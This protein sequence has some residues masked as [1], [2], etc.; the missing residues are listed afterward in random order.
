MYSL[1][2]LL[3]NLL[4]AESG[5]SVYS[6]NPSKAAAPFVIKDIGSAKYVVQA[7]EPSVGTG[8]DDNGQ[9]WYFE[10]TPTMEV[11]VMGGGQVELLSL[12]IVE[13]TNIFSEDKMEHVESPAS[14][15]SPWVLEIY[16]KDESRPMDFTFQGTVREGTK[17]K[18]FAESVTI[19][20]VYP[21]GVQQTSK[22]ISPDD[23]VKLAKQG[24]TFE[25]RDTS[26][27]IRQQEAYADQD[28]YE[29]RQSNAQKKA[30]HRQE[31]ARQFAD[32]E[33]S[34]RF[35]EQM[36]QESIERKQKEEEYWETLNTHMRDIQEAHEA[37]QKSAKQQTT[38]YYSP[39]NVA[40]SSSTSQSSSYSSGSGGSSSSTASETTSKYETAVDCRSCLADSRRLNAPSCIKVLDKRPYNGAGC[41]AS[42]G[43]PGFTWKV[44]NGCGEKV[45]FRYVFG[46]TSGNPNAKYGNDENSAQLNGGQQRTLGGKCGLDGTLDMKAVFSN[47]SGCDCDSYL[48]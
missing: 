27:Y 45:K 8:Q 28:E 23:V 43:G 44:Q 46:L 1:V 33:S 19:E 11:R 47:V 15:S 31:S 37:S 4:M 22:R 17:T 12:E 36:Y 30:R 38:E 14:L 25:H 20:N 41:D 32:S 29:S 13:G 24:H 16:P 39:T 6:G 3:P 40:P 34:K 2:L 5:V 18:N 7:V 10:N 9:Y 26:A 48:Y 35:G 42:L 21:M